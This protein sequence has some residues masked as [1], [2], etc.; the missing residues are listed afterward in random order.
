VKK[1]RESANAQ[2]FRAWL[3]EEADAV[4]S[5]KRAAGQADSRSATGK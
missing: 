2:A 1:R 4:N 5:S 3:K